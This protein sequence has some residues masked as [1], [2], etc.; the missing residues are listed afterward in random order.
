MFDDTMVEEEDRGEQKKWLDHF[1]SKKNHPNRGDV[2]SEKKSLEDSEEGQDESSESVED[3]LVAE[4]AELRDKFMRTLAELDNTR[5]RS[6]E[7]K[8]KIS[9]Y[10]IA[11]FVK[12][13]TNVMENFYLAMN[14]VAGKEKSEDLKVFYGG[15]ELTFSEMRKVFEKNNIKRIY[16]LNEQFDPNY[17][18]AVTSIESNNTAGTIIEVMQAG[19]IL[20]GRVIK[21]ALVVVAK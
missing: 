12:D 19:Y 13:L 7:E 18:E 3:K 4:N 17:H 14:S 15:I 1:R 16:P 9:K 2:V 10:A 20:N 5:K 8:E 21:P 11:N 6:S